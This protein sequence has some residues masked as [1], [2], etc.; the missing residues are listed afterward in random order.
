MTGK[1]S[2]NYFTPIINLSQMAPNNQERIVNES[3]ANAVDTFETTRCDP[4]DHP[5]FG[6]KARLIQV[7]ANM[8]YKN[9]MCQDLVSTH[10]YIFFI[11]FLFLN[12]EYIL[13]KRRQ[14][15][16]ENLPSVD[17]EYSSCSSSMLDPSV[18]SRCAPRFDAGVKR[19][20]LSVQCTQ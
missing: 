6:F 12:I 14:I 18:L 3:S 13:R 20:R 1:S 7:I 4:Q 10:L 19:I 11:L 8:V 2:D 17:K 16:V 15:Y 9:R 5:A